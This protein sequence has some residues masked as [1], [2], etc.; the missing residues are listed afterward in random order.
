MIDAMIEK[1]YDKCTGCCACSNIC[2][3]DAISMNEDNEGFKYPVVDENKCI[4]CGLCVNVCPTINKQIKINNDIKAYACINKDTDIRL[5]SSSG[6]IFS[7][8]ADYI[9]S[10]NG[11]V[12][13]AA[14]DKAWNVEHTYIEDIDDLDKLRTSKYVQS[15]IGVNYK[16]VKE[17]LEKGKLVLFTGTPC[18]IAGLKA[19][20]GKDYDN[21]YCMDIICHGVP[22]PLV[23]R[24]FLNENYDVDDIKAIN[25]RNKTTGWSGF[26]FKVQYTN[27][28]IIENRD[29]NL[30]M[31]GFLSDL[32]LRPSCYNCS[33]KTVERVSDITIADFWGIN[34]ILP[35]M[36]DEKGT[37]LIFI[38]SNKGKCLINKVKNNIELYE[39]DVNKAISFNSSMIKSVAKH[40][41]REKF[42]KEIMLQ[43]NKIN[44]VIE[45]YY[46]NGGFRKKLS[47]RIRKNIRKL[48]SRNKLK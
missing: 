44:F 40:R 30:Y 26:S 7:V 24:R 12:F 38:Q 48:F 16:Y 21:L 41:H 8:I 17:F 10:N 15:Y 42:F 13:G 25:F 9:L 22:S 23:W 36:N 3:K 4:N 43:K 11:I 29:S 39:V 34:E 18:Q 5:K 46:I 6:G 35:K 1:T 32:Y 37:S 19:Y 20:L 2:P 45:K 28:A 33:F 14:F 31:I 27:K 47:Y